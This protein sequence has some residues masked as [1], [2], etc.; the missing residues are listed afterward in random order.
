[1]RVLIVD[2]SSTA[3]RFL[4]KALPEQC[5]SDVVEADG[6]RRGLELCREGG[7]DLMFLDLTMPE[8]DGYE[9]LA[10]LGARLATLPVIVVSGDVQTQAP[11]RAKGLG[12]RAFIKKP[13]TKE[14]VEV[15]LREIGVL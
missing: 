8:M 3:R 7:I 11:E 10:A 9:V 6:A 4:K 1:M 14:Q 12:A 13:A 15:V 5:L 2:D